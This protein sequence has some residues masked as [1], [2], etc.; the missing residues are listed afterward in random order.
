[1]R[2]SCASS[3]SGLSTGIAAIVVQLGLAMMPRGTSSSAWELTSATTSGTSASR[4]KAELLST[5]VTP[6]AANRGACT[7]EV[8]AP[9]ENSATSGPVWAAVAAAAAVICPAPRGRVLP[10]LRAEAKNRSSASGKRRSARTRRM[11]A[12][13]GPPAPPGPD[14]GAPPAGCGAGPHAVRGGREAAL[15]GDPAQDGADLP[16]GADDPD[17]EPVA[18]ELGG[19]HRPVP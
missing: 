13:T 16:G 14:R 9:A 15:G 10:A 5:T 2:T 18:G 7:R 1:M 3:C 12:P 19:G 17:A 8:A 6:A 4:R 11:T